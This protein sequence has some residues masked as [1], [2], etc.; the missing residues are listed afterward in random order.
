MIFEKIKK[1][2]KE[3]TFADKD[4]NPLPD[5]VKKTEQEDAAAVAE[6]AKED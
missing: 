6:V 5:P 3:T 1:T 2:G 4:W